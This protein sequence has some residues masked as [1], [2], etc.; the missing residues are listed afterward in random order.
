MTELTDRRPK[1]P[2]LDLDAILSP[3]PDGDGCG[4]DLRDVADSPF[5]AIEE[6]RRQDDDLPQGVWVHERKTADW[7]QVVS[8]CQDVLIRRSKDLRV[9]V[10]LV[11]ALVSRDGFAALAPSFGLIEALCATFWDGIH[12]LPDEDGDLA[13]RMNAIAVLNSRLPRLLRTLPI[14]RSGQVDVVSFSWGDYEN[15]RLM[16]TR[17][18]AR[19]GGG[20]TLAA[21]E[22]SAMATPVARLE[23][24]REDVDAGR[25]AL[26]RLDAFLDDA[27]RRQAPSL[28]AL[29]EL[30]AGI[31][32]WLHTVIPARPAAEAVAAEVLDEPMM[33]QA[34]APPPAAS[35]GPIAS[36]ED[37]YRR[38]AEI[39]D[40]LMRTEPHSPTPYVLRR[41]YAWG[42]MP[43]HQLLLD[44]AQGRN[45]LATIIDLISLNEN[46]SAR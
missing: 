7:S 25:A 5:A 43:L 9:A 10:W 34:D 45:D 18:L 12:P 36:R 23:A 38:L 2:G 42:R 19:K 30:L 16:E 13:A 44:M 21:F 17:G 6:A 24:L 22:S 35:G 8:L 3:L 37:A 14:T 32:G 41:L 1:S 26:D 33:S 15:A 20:L 31:A 29:T 11:E 27:G 39:A 46:E 4:F 28:G 40:Y